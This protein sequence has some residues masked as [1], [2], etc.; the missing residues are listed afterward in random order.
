MPAGSPEPWCSC[1]G[2]GAEASPVCTQRGVGTLT[3]IPVQEPVHGCPGLG[4]SGF[5]TKASTLQSPSWPA[6]LRFPSAGG[7]SSP[8]RGACWEPAGS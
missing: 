1:G 5:P 2:A 6:L 3:C 8:G 4:V 7:E